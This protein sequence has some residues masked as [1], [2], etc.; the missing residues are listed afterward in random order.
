MVNQKSDNW[1]MTALQAKELKFRLISARHSTCDKLLCKKYI[2]D[3]NK[4]MK[5][6]K[7]TSFEWVRKND[8]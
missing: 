1:Q 2:D 4:P 6:Y 3:Y 8:H 5:K 7:D